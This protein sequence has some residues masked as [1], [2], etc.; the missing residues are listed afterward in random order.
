MRGTLSQR[1]PKNLFGKMLRMERYLVDI[2]IEGKLRELIFVALSEENGFAF[3]ADIKPQETAT[4]T[5]FFS[6]KEIANLTF[7]IAPINSWSRLIPT[8]DKWRVTS[9]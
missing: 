5:T 9:A 2:G 3:W 6:K 4:R 1:V 7:E 8:G